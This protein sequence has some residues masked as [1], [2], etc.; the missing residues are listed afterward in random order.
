M[1]TPTLTR[2]LKVGNVRTYVDEVNALAPNDAPIKAS[3]V[4]ADLALIINAWNDPGSAFPPTGPAAG[5]LAG[6]TYPNP[7]IAPG[8]VTAAKIAA[9]VIPTTLPPTGSA[10]GDL[11]GSYP[12]PTINPTKLP[13]SVSG[14]TL[15]PTDATKTVALHG[16]GE[17]IVCDV[18]GTQKA[19]IGLTG[20]PGLALRLNGN[21]AGTAADDTTKPVWHMQIGGSDTWQVFRAPA[22]AGAPAF[23]LLLSLDATGQAILPGDATGATVLLGAA[24]AKGRLQA[25]TATPGTVGILANRN[26]AAGNAQD[27]PTK[28]SWAAICNCAGDV[29]QVHRSPAGSTTQTQVLQVDASGNLIMSGPT[30]TKSTGTTWANPSDPRLK[31][32]IAP[33]TRGL[34]DILPLEPITYRL[35]AQPDGPLCYGFDASK[36][37]A[38]FPECVSE[39]R[40]TLPGETEP[41]DGVLAFDLHPILVASV[42]ALKELAARVAALEGTA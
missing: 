10:G 29:F 39:T 34:A 20:A 13:W 36:V 17:S 6:S 22:S 40:M 7:V 23:N 19:H 16:P 12:A 2:P 21:L 18:G 25:L 9:G 26:W 42:N 33:Y 27:D 31:D 4:D 37:Q 3:E 1:G 30:G 15:T 28:P 32:D 5:D 11:Q 38:V 24:T 35:K 41:T 8:A 14:S